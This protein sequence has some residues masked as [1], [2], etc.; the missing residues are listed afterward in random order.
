M[1]QNSLGTYLLQQPYFFFRTFSDVREYVRKRSVG[2]TYTELFECVGEF[3][4]VTACRS[5][6]PLQKPNKNDLKPTTQEGK[7]LSVR[8]LTF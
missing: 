5:F 4:G 2:H 8:I 1:S 3:R 7:N 6:A